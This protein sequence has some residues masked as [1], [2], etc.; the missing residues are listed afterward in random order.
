MKAFKICKWNK[1]P[2][3]PV[4]AMDRHRIYS[5]G[6][7]IRTLVLL[8]GCPLRCRY[9]PNRYTWNS[10]VKKIGDARICSTDVEYFTPQRLFN[11]IAVDDLYFNA[12]GGG[13]TF[14]G[15][16]PLMHM[17]GIR[18]F[19]DLCSGEW[20]I[21]AETSLYV[22][23]E[24]VKQAAECIDFFIVDI[25]STDADIYK[26]YTGGL[27][28]VMMKNLRFLLELAGP[29]RIKVRIPEIP[30]YADRIMQEESYRLMRDIGIE[31]IELFRYTTTFN[32]KKVGLQRTQCSVNISG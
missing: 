15:G 24:Y 28:S 7:G 23:R 27:V 30:G 12:T 3:L 18:D 5:D 26:T 29:K 1:I 32:E 2:L 25:K 6:P 20:K 21:Y 10:C 14:G 16:E 4:A 17:R 19:A 11:T 22:P 9:C 8:N 13:V 31:N